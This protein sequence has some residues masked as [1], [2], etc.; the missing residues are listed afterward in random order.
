MKRP[1]GRNSGT[2]LLS[3]FLTVPLYCDVE[4]KRYPKSRTNV[5]LLRTNLR[6]KSTKYIV[7]T[8]NN[9]DKLILLPS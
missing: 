5:S 3:V 9:A 4:I 6:S 1:L 7:N 8:I 2:I